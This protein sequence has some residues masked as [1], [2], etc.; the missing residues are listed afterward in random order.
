MGGTTLAES[1][2]HVSIKGLFVIVLPELM[3]VLEWLKC[4]HK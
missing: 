4:H 1:V 2:W 3:N